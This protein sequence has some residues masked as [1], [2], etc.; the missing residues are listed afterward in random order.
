MKNTGA[1][2][3]IREVLRATQEGVSAFY[4]RLGFSP[5]RV[6]MER[7]GADRSGDGRGGLAE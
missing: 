6:A 1:S 3:E 5:S 7:P 2:M 4:E